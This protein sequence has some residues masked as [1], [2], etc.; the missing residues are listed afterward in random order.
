MLGLGK[1]TTG[2]HRR[3]MEVKT[4]PHFFRQEM[5]LPGVAPIA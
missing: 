2:E 4:T 1:C 3:S 5:R